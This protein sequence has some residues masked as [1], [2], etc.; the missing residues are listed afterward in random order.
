MDACT[1]R[2]DACT[3]RADACTVR[4]RST[5]DTFEAATGQ[6]ELMLSVSRS[7]QAEKNSCK[8]ELESLVSS[9]DQMEVG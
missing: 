6:M 9:N 5:T 7:L 8:E 1:V 2:A 3:S 4:L